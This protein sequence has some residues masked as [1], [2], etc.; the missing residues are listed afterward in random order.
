[1]T[2]H[3]LVIDDDDMVRE[4]VRMSLEH[5][6]RWQVEEASS[7][8]TGVAAARERRPDAVL[9]DVMMPGT[10]G[11]ATYELLRAHES[12]RDVP[13]V[14][15]TA[16][17]MRDE[18]VRLAGTGAVGVVGKPFDPLQLPGELAGLLGWA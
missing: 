11:P 18:Q 17:L 5:V 15:L 7:G 2:R 4:V 3:V 6:A 10:D 16:K 1:M 14:F 9:L 13:V 8:P 12:T